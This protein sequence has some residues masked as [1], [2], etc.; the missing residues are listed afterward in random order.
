MEARTFPRLLTVPVR[1]TRNWIERIVEMEGVD[2][3]VV[4]GAQAFTALFP[5]LIVYAA[6]VAPG[7]ESGFVERLIARLE[8]EGT[9]A[10][11]LRRAFTPPPP[12]EGGITAVGAVLVIVSALTFARAMQRLYER[13]WKLEP[14]GMR[15]TGW[16]L[17]WLGGL[18]VVL[19]LRTIADMELTGTADVAASLALG[20]VVWL[21]TPFV[22]LARR[23]PF[24]ALLPSAVLTAAAMFVFS[25]VMVVVAPRTFGTSAE[26]YGLIGVAFAIVGWLISASL[27]VM[28]STALGAVIAERAGFGRRGEAFDATA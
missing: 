19:T 27:V 3:A 11:T 24:A 1:V 10:E 7:G 4:L 22:L 23:V 28:A 6:L 16:G 21:A 18:T 13:A 17:L 26:A 14:L 8:I 5:L 12:A 9:S 25:I 15:A 20:T 2:R